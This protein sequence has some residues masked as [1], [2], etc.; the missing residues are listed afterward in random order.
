MWRFFGNPAANN[1][2]LPGVG[3]ATIYFP[4]LTRLYAVDLE[5]GA[6]KWQYPADAPLNATIIG[7]PV[8]GDGLVY[9]GASN[10]NVLALDINT[11]SLRWV[12]TA[13]SAPTARPCWTRACCMSARGAANCT[14]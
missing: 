1:P 13:D 10:G 6:L 14:R 4:C 2:A 9:V 3:K 7:Q 5:S 8:E 11:G 12:F